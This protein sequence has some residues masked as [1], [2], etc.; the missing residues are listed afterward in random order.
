V[1]AGLVVLL[2]ISGLF[3]WLARKSHAHDS[4]PDAA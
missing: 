1:A 4:P 3:V 2:S